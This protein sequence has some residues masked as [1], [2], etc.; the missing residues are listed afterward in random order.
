MPNIFRY[1]DYRKYLRDA[2]KAMRKKDPALSYRALA[3]HIGLL[4][5]S[6]IFLV[7]QSKRNLGDSLLLRFSA[8]L[9]LKRNEMFY[10][11]HMT[12]Y[13]QS[14]TKFE[15]DEYYRRMVAMNGRLKK[16]K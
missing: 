12:H 15:K 6:H 7:I 3:K 13:N 5:P 16:R 9:K 10:L 4:A 11:E 8:F 2:I 1:T 14:Q